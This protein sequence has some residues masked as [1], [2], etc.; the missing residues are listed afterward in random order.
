LE[1]GWII[2]R[3]PNAR[4]TGIDLS[5]NMLAQLRSKQ[6]DRLEQIGLIQGSYLQVPFGEARFDFAISVMTLHHLLPD[7]KRQ[8]YARI[9]KAL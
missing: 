8:L 5:G 9:R 1:L 2:D 3:E 6:A 7:R 4:I